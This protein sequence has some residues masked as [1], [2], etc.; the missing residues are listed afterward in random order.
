MLVTSV[1]DIDKQRLLASE[2]LDQDRRSE[3]GQFMTP[4]AVA[5]F[6]ALQFQNWPDEIR[7]LDPGA[8]I[9]SLTE[10]FTKRFVEKAVPGSKLHVSAFEI[11]KVLLK[12]L[13]KNLI[14][15]RVQNSKHFVTHEVLE[16]DFILGNRLNKGD[17]THVILNPP[18]K[19]ILASSDYRKIMQGLGVEAPNLYVAFL[20]L[21]ILFAKQDAEIVAII[22]RSFCNGSYFLPF[23]KW[24]FNQVGLTHIHVFRSRRN[25]FQ[26][27]KI[28][29]ENIIIRLVKGAERD[30]VKIS[31]SNDHSFTD[32]VE[33]T[34]SFNKVVEI[35]DKEMYIRV[36]D[37]QDTNLDLFT[38]TLSELRVEVSTGPV[39][40][41][42]AKD[43]LLMNLEVSSVPLLYPHH[44]SNGEVVWP[45]LHK[46]AN[47]LK[48]TPVTSK[49]LMPRGWYLII[50]RFS[51]KEEKRRIVAHVVS[52]EKL[53][54]SLY[55]FENHL[56]VIHSN[57]QGISPELVYG[58]SVFLNSTLVDKHFRTFSGHTQV[59]ATDLR[60]M[61]FPDMQT[62]L[63]FG[64]WAQNQS[65][66]TQVSIDDFIM[67]YVRKQQTVA[68]KSS[69]SNSRKPRHAKSTAQ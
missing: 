65:A 34:V 26:D 19:K 36:P 35:D 11:E 1:R 16:K 56:N 10:A 59:N 42:R 37:I 49:L 28:L 54:H 20:A 39:V 52:P 3:L 51:S 43:S 32:Y 17:F 40:D 31:E 5:D 47:A 45:K 18:Y 33:R 2:Q 63:Y 50:K 30:D 60:N 8:G 46:K 4:S 22:P 55:A 23:R 57:K 41:F 53:K 66:L 69:A 58:L 6:M 13:K 7:L 15:L 29:Q 61:R 38:H 48:I 24:L 25:A 62:L 67:Q 44:F 21:S 12:H 27:D 68:S 9:G 14:D 64:Q